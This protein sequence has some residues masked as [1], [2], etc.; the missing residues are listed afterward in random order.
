MTG[1]PSHLEPSASDRRVSDATLL[2]VRLLARSAAR[3]AVR[4]SALAEE[5]ADGRDQDI[6]DQ[7][8]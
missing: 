1:E 6:P 3:D 5:R 7:T 4:L 8:R 2:L